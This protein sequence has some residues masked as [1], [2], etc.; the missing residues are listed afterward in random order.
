MHLALLEKSQAKDVEIIHRR[1]AKATEGA[2]APF[3]VF[4]KTWLQNFGKSGALLPNYCDRYRYLSTASA[5]LWL[6]DFLSDAGE[7]TST[8]SAYDK[9]SRSSS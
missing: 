6:T 2:L 1:N 3:A 9:I 4:V 8:L 7:I 5:N